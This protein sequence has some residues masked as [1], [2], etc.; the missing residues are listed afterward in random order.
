MLR[1][2]GSYLFVRQPVRR[3]DE[4]KKQIISSA[5]EILQGVPLATEPSISLINLPL[6]RILVSSF[7]DK[8]LMLDLIGEIRTYSSSNF[9]AISSL[10]LELLKKSWVR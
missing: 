5:C 3:P 7:F 9:V 2:K 8:A 4:F 6:M 10:V 1:F